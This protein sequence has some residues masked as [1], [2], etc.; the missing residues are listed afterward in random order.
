MA[1]NLIGICSDHAG[2]DLKIHVIDLLH[3]MGYEVED[4]GC[5]SSERCDY[6]DYAHPMAKAIQDGHLERGISICGS[7]NGI[8]MVVN[9]YGKLRAALCWCVEIAQ[10]A[11]QHNNA[12]VLSMP[13]RFISEQEADE[14]VKAFF[15]TDFEGGRH[16]E[17]INKI[18]IH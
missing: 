3:K 13:A 12:N 15:T 18:P 10:L 7:G 4:F 6:P 14:I 8:S 1:N 9:K 2:Y 17:R 5:P 16:I 11:R